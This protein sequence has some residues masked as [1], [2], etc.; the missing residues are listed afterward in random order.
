MIAE[1][2]TRPRKRVMRKRRMAKMRRLSGVKRAR[3]TMRS[4]VLSRK[5]AVPMKMVM[6]EGIRSHDL[7]GTSGMLYDKYKEG[8]TI[9]KLE[10]QN[11]EELQNG[12]GKCQLNSI[13]AIAKIK[14]ASVLSP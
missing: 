4:K 6:M 14:L 12:C 8:I 10:S 3:I 9:T 1:L 11:G 7:N 5:V 2:S 13:Y